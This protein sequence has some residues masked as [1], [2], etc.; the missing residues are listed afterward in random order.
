MAEI[1]MSDAHAWAQKH[2][3]GWPQATQGLAIQLIVKYGMPA[4]S[5]AHELAWYDNGPWKRTVLHRKEVPHNFPLPHTDVLEQTVDYRV[6]PQKAALLIQ[7]NGSLVIDRTRGELSAHC[8]SE[9]HNILTLNLAHDILR[10]ERDVDL[11]LTY[12]AQVI[13][14]LQTHVD[15]PYPKK[16]RFKTPA[17]SAPTADPGEEAPLLKH[18]DE[19]IVTPPD[20]PP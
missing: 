6:P 3:V 9:S 12:H 11:A 18:L 8:D 17:P 7:Y 5:S 10:G 4:D 13:R 1:S 19:T 20:A 14:G 2:L 15:E 16:L